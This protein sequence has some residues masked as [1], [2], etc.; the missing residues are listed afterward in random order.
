M[1]FLRW[2][3]SSVQASWASRRDS[4]RRWEETLK[5]VVKKFA[6]IYNASGKQ[7]KMKRKGLR[8]QKSDTSGHFILFAC[9]S[10]SHTKF[11][12]H[13]HSRM[14]RTLNIC[15]VNEQNSLT[16][17]NRIVS[18]FLNT[19]CRMQRLLLNRLKHKT[20][21]IFIKGFRL[22][23]SRSFALPC[24]LLF[25]AK[26]TGYPQTR[27]Q[28]HHV[29]IHTQVKLWYM[30]IRPHNA[31]PSSSSS[32]SLIIQLFFPCSHSL[33]SAVFRF[34]FLLVRRRSANKQY[35]FLTITT[36]ATTTTTTKTMV[37]C[38]FYS[39]TLFMRRHSVCSTFTRQLMFGMR[40]WRWLWL[41][42]MIMCT[43]VC[44][45]WLQEN[46]SSCGTLLSSC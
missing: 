33:S 19:F 36:T 24:I 29:P 7:R 13:T 10:F 2:S 3:S 11:D 31:S 22:I 4:K 16:A 38:V 15:T 28:H 26:R 1:H 32:S 42:I 20:F 17:I 39:F 44:P 46:S 12:A 35:T 23:F 6:L 25:V 43:R 14:K 34:F 45:H 9:S 8:T 41:L 37:I 30:A 27:R 5:R 18:R 21:N 40:A